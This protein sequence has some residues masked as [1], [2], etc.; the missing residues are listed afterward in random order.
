V[1]SHNSISAKFTSLSLF[2]LK[3]LNFCVAIAAAVFH[4]L[5]FK[6]PGGGGLLF[7]CNHPLT[8]RTTNQT[9]KHK[10]Q[11]HPHN[12]YFGVLFFFELSIFTLLLISV[13]TSYNSNTTTNNNRD[14]IIC[15]TTKTR[16]AQQKQTIR[17]S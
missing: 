10:N 8:A 4:K 11:S 14:T 6:N 1:F 7:R 2:S 13:V 17:N 12:S 16:I 3:H 5:E 15:T 9:T